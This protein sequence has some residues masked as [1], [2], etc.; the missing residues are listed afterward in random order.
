M[1]LSILFYLLLFFFI[2][3]LAA[4]WIANLFGLPGNWLIVLLTAIWFFCTDPANHWHIGIWL[5]V[6]FVVLAGIGELIEFLASVLVTRKV[7]GSKRAA[8]FSVIGSI[9]G[10]L[11]GG[12]VGLPIPIPLVGM[13]VGSVIFACVGALL[14]ATIGERWQ[15]SEIEK[16]LKVG[17]AAAAGRFVG[18]MGKIA[19]GSSILAIAIINLFI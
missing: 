5:I 18:T 3:A 8:T 11:I 7:G 12:I 1:I 10:G 13:I 19:M 17:G 15:G 9:V 6:L 14:G 2:V 4:C 16:S